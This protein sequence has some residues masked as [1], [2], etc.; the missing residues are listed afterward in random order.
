MGFRPR[1]AC[2]ARG[3]IELPVT[4]YQTGGDENGKVIKYEIDLLHCGRTEPEDNT[5]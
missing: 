5:L 3:K 2:N 4:L 1:A